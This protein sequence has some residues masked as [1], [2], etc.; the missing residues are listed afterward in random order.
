M[1]LDQGTDRRVLTLVFHPVHLPVGGLDEIFRGFGI[2][3]KLFGPMLA[4]TKSMVCPS[5]SKGWANAAPIRSSTAP[6]EQWSGLV[7]KIVNSS[8]PMRAMT[9][10]SRN[11]L[12]MR[13]ATSTSN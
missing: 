13:L 10:V 5:I 3:G 8:P 7:S 4:E 6:V 1:L 12:R 11:S 9:S 2:G